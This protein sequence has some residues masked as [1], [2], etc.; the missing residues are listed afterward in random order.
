VKR[1]TPSRTKT[2]EGRKVKESITVRLTKEA[3]QII[4][5]EAAENGL[6]RTSV[7]ELAVRA[8]GRSKGRI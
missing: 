2:Q 8:Y 5:D 3:M 1:K 7:V 4:L 6:D